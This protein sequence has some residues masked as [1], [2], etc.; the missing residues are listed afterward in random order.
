MTIELHGIELH[1]FHGVLEHERREGQR[2]LVDVDLDLSDETAAATD[3]IED[4]V[5][6]R[7]VVSAVAEVSEARRFQLLEAFAAAIA[8]ALVARFPVTRVRVRVRKPDVVL[9]HPVDHAAVVVERRTS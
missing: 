4:A 9:S 3:R 5:D 8:E 1:G 2:F 6:Y 7:D